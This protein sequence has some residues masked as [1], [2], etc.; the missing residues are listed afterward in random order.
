MWPQYRQALL[1]N[2]L[3]DSNTSTFYKAQATNIERGRPK[4]KAVVSHRR[5]SEWTL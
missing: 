4:G 2:H 5:L 1:V 3:C